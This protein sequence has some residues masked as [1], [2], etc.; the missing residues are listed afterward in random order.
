MVFRNIHAIFEPV[1]N[2]QIIEKVCNGFSR[3]FIVYPAQMV[4]SRTY[5]FG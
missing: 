5:L 4:G 1:S 2:R 3:T